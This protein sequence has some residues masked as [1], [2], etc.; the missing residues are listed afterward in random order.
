M[1]S[2]IVIGYAI[3]SA[4]AATAAQQ[5][6]MAAIQKWNAAKVVH[7]KI[8]GVYRGTVPIARGQD[9]QYAEAVVNDAFTVDVDLEMRHLETVGTPKFANAKTTLTGVAS[10]G[11]VKCPPP[12]PQGEF[13]YFEVTKVV[14]KQSA[15][16]L[17]GT[18]TFPSIGLSN[19]WPSSCAQQ[20]VA[21]GTDPVSVT[22]AVPSPVMLAL[23]GGADPKFSIAP[24][25]KSFVFKAG[26]WTWTYTPSVVQ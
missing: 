3:A 8:S 2:A 25:R 17:Q 22:I 26:D 10:P 19:Q 11:I 7:Y 23:P 1:R 13:E 4:A 20:N 12:T 18:R 16:E 14:T 15:L 5:F 24:D 6:D 9:A 21:G